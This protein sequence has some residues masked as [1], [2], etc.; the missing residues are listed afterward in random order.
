MCPTLAKILPNKNLLNAINILQIFYLYFEI[1]Y[2]P[3]HVFNSQIKISLFLE[4]NVM[5][6]FLEKLWRSNEMIIHPSVLV[7]ISLYQLHLLWLLAVGDPVVNNQYSI[8]ESQNLYQS[9]YHWWIVNFRSIHRNSWWWRVRGG[10][11]N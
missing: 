7:S 8:F 4:D 11:C 6:T 1:S 10:W 3:F 9:T 5:S 2:A